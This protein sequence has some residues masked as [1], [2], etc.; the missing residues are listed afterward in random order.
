M[1]RACG[2]RR[3][4]RPA[5]IEKGEGEEQAGLGLRAEMKKGERKGIEIAFH[6]LKPFSKYKFKW[7]LNF[8]ANF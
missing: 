7:D 3:E 4:S 2:K 5:G 6:F 8:F 1:E